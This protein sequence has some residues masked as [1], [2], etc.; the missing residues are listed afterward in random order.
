MKMCRGDR[1]NAATGG[2]KMSKHVQ[3][4]DDFSFNYDILTEETVLVTGG[5]KVCVAF[6][7]TNVSKHTNLHIHTNFAVY[8]YRL[9]Q[10]LI[11]QMAKP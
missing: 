8:V 5:F 1:G 7:G 3:G 6:T 2:M 9:L 11:K 4:K 10:L